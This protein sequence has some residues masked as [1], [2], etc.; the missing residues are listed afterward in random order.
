MFVYIN[1]TLQWKSWRRHQM[2]TLSGL[3]AL[4][5]GNS[6]VTGE[7]SPQRPVTRSFDVFFDL[8]LNKRLSKHSRRHQAHYDVTLPCGSI[9]ETHDMLW[10][11]DITL[12]FSL[13][14]QSVVCVS[15]GSGYDKYY[16]NKP[17]IRQRG[18]TNSDHL[19]QQQFCNI[20][21]LV[22]V[23][24]ECGSNRKAFISKSNIISPFLNK[25]SDKN[26]HISHYSDVTYASWRFKS[27]ARHLV[28]DDNKNLQSFAILVLC[29]GIPSITGGF[30]SQRVRNIESI[31]ISWRHDD[32]KVDWA[33]PITSKLNWNWAHRMIT[34][35]V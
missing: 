11:S 35:M 2:E 18:R 10:L 17:T 27:P 6:P 20:A 1:Y 15:T 13:V 16:A 3:L 22:S 5:V 26:I 12:P 21:K 7:F 9:C 34:N 32:N 29:E 30:P 33:P 25:K 31:S 14:Y 4:C 24:F 19:S 28:Q 8:R 23:S